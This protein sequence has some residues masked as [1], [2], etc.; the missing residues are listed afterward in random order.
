MYGADMRVICE[1]GFYKFFPDYI[2]EV[3]LWQNRNGT[4]LYP[5]DDYFTF[6][7]LKDFQ[8]YSF[9]GQ[10]IG[11]LPAIANYEGTPWG[12]LAKNKLTYNIKLGTI[13]PRATASIKRLNYATGA[14]ISTP[15]LPQAFAL[16]EDLQPITGFSAFVDVKMGMY[17]IERF[18]YE[19]I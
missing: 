5:K 15:E 16:D 4:R 6:E 12:T 1:L 17:K 14:F 13:T 8:N 18:F 2:G 10:L 9:T 3:M 19:D 7:A 11:L